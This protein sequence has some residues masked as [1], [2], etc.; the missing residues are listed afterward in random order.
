MD[1]LTD[2]ERKV[3]YASSERVINELKYQICNVLS[4]IIWTTW[5]IAFAIACV[6][7][8]LLFVFVIGSNID[9]YGRQIDVNDHRAINRYVNNVSFLVHIIFQTFVACIVNAAYVVIM[10]FVSDCCDDAVKYYKEKINPKG[11]NC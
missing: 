9:I 11:K 5:Y 4:Y 8:V 1:T 10:Y 3:A 7:F 2:S 6:T